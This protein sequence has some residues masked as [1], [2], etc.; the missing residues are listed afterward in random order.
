MVAALRKLFEAAGVSDRNADS[1]AFSVDIT[2]AIATLHVHW[3]ETGFGDVVT[4]HTKP[5]ISFALE[6]G[7]AHK[8]F[9][10]GDS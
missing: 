1:W 7:Y 3:A 8:D 9:T 5:V 10:H 6:Y 2:T 4:H